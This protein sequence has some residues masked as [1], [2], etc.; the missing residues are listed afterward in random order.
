LT[1]DASKARAIDHDIV[2]TI[3]DFLI[4]APNHNISV[5]V[6]D[7]YGKENLK[8]HEEFIILKDHY[9]KSPLSKSVILD[10]KIVGL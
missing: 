1:I 2:E 7:L 3:D 5:E 8:T 9:D 6:Y 10:K 4:T